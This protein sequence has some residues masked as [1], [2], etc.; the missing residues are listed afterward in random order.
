M[1]TELVQV[2]SAGAEPLTTLDAKLWLRVDS[3]DT[4]EDDLIASLC[5]AARSY[6]EAFCRRTFKVGDTWKLTADEFPRLRFNRLGDGLELETEFW[7][8]ENDYLLRRPDAYAITIPMG[9]ISAIS[10]INYF[11]TD[12][13]SQVLDPATYTFVA[14]DFASPK[15]YPNFAKWWPATQ[16]RPDA[17]AINFVSTG[18]VPEPVLLAMKQMLAHWYAN[19]ES[20]AAGSYQ[21]VPQLAEA[22]M[23]PY[24]YLEL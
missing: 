13:V 1:K 18:V 7:E 12:G 4:G 10:S 23:W 21:K 5:V 17:V 2:A 16:A 8:S 14:D 19:R 24:R 9:P 3:G 22:L 11:D 20:V 6:A 15:V